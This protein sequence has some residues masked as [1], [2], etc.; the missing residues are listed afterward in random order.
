MMKAAEV[1]NYIDMV[2][3]RLLR[4]ENTQVQNVLLG[5]LAEFQMCALLDSISYRLKQIAEKK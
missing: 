5:V 3:K 4:E 1:N 2:T